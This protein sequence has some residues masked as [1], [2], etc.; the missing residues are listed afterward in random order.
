MPG[1]RWL[2]LALYCLHL[3]F[4]WAEDPSYIKTSDGV[5]VFTDPAFTGTSNAVKLEVVADNIIRVIACPV[6]EITPS[7]S[8]VTVYSKRQDLSRNVTSSKENLTLKTKALTAIINLKTGIVSFW[9]LKGKW[10]LGEKAVARRSFWPAVFEGKRLYH[11]VQTFQTTPD[12]GW[13]GLGQ[14]QSG[15]MNY[16]GQQVNFFQ[17]NTEVAVPFLISSK[18]YGI[19][20]DN[21]SLTSVGDVRPLHQLSSF[22]LFSKN[23]AIIPIKYSEPLK[24]IIIG[25]RKGEFDGMPKKK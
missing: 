8:L 10:I 17:N 21:Y 1:T 19:L 20:W 14:H 6:K 7:Q 12:D 5:I 15:I 2:L 16:R 4:A 18:N 24:T 9:D 3:Q 11:L 13:Y 22:A 25:E 23:G